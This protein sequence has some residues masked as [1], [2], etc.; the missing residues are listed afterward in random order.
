MKA[1][2]LTPMAAALYIIIADTTGSA[3]TDRPGQQKTRASM[4]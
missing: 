2:I 3:N 4:A 1:G